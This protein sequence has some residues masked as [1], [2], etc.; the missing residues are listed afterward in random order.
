M[1][2]PKFILSHYK[3]FMLLTFPVLNPVLLVK[4]LSTL[5]LHF[6][7]PT[8]RFMLCIQK[9]H[10]KELIVCVNCSLSK[11][12][13]MEVYCFVSSILLTCCDKLLFLLSC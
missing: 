2:V 7:P 12:I 11:A 13:C 10:T 6:I 3:F 9:F 1:L 5:F 8:Y 4:G